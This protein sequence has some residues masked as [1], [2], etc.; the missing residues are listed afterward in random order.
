MAHSF[1]IEFAYEFD[2]DDV[3]TFLERFATANYN[4]LPKPPVKTPATQSHGLQP[5]SE[6]VSKL[7]L[8]RQNYKDHT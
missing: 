6:Y 4:K 3:F 1:V 8:P 5:G 7:R 2:G